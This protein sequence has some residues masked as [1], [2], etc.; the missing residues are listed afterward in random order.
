MIPVAFL[1]TIREILG[2][3]RL[4]TRLNP[5]LQFDGEAR[6][7][8][9]HYHSIFGGSLTIGTYRDYGKLEPEVADLVMHAVLRTAEDLTLMGFDSHPRLPFH[10]GANVA[11]CLT[12][13]DPDTLSGY[14]AHLSDGGQ[15]RMPLAEQIWGDIFGMCEDRFGVTWMINIDKATE[16]TDPA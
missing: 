10:V 8:M 7:A 3:H 11:I 13:N 4:A 16:P 5:Y 12:G 14:W 6:E 15:V 9:E 1:V 2:E